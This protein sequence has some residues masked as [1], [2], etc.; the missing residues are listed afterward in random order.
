[1]SEVLAQIRAR[2]GAAEARVIV[3]GPDAGFVAAESYEPSR[4]PLTPERAEALI[5]DAHQAER[6]RRLIAARDFDD[7]LVALQEEHLRVLDAHANALPLC[8][9][10][11]R[12][13]ST[14]LQQRAHLRCWLDRGHDGA[15]TMGANMG[16]GHIRWGK[17]IHGVTG[18]LGEFTARYAGPVA[19]LMATTGS[20]RGHLIRIEVAG[21]VAAC[22]YAT[23]AGTP[24][25]HEIVIANKTYLRREMA[26]ALRAFAGATRLMHAAT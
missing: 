24:L 16:A 5:A 19:P 14:V 20:R 22:G 6:L 23:S 21:G 9:T 26:L 25:D 8:R 10:M 11:E 12:T 13:R 2:P 7:I 15:A 1:V 18:K 4:T 3:L 17:A